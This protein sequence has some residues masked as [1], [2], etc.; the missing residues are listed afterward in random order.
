MLD[1]CLYFSLRKIRVL[2]SVAV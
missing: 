1:I 2:F